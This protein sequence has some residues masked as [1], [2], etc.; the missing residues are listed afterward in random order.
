MTKGTL[1][2]RFDK[3]RDAA[4][5]E[6]PDVEDQIRNFQFRDLRAKAGTDK[7]ERDGIYAAQQQLAHASVTTTEIYAGRKGRKATPTR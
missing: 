2:S 4:I 6:R 5:A 1:R 7:A 3:A